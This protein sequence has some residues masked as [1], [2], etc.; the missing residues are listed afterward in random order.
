MIRN[1]ITHQ[2][3]HDPH[4]TWRGQSVTRIENLSDVVFALALGMLVSARSSMLTFSDLNSHLLN[5]VPVAAGFAI[6]LLIWNTHFVF[7]RR[8]GLADGMIVFLNACMLLVI[9]FLAYPLRFIFDSLFGFIF[10]LFGNEARAATMQIGYRESGV[11]VAYFAAGYAVVFFIFSQMYRC[12]LKKAESLEL[13]P[14]EI[15][16]TKQSIWIF[17]AQVFCAGLVFAGA[18]FTPAS[19]FSAFAFWL[20]APVEL[21]IKRRF[22]LP[23]SPQRSGAS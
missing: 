10:T 13:S 12:A 21:L 15:V 1:A 19:A 9:L 16:M 22:K 8:Y 14:I 2:L 17:R 7:F 5:I 23:A 3:N 11:I 18:L 20:M 6:F 4:F